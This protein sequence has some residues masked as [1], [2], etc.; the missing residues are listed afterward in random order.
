MF[1]P[2]DLS[3]FAD[4]VLDELA[5]GPLQLENTL[6][7]DTISQA[8][9][10]VL[11]LGC[12]YG[13]VT[14]PL[15]QRGIDITGLDLSAPSLDYARQQAADLP[16]RWIEADVRDFH[17]G[18]GY[19]LIF[20]RG[21]IFNFML[22][23]MDQEA[24]L[25]CV[26][27]HMGH[28]ARFLFDVCYVHPDELVDDREEEEWA[29][30]TDPQGRRLYVAGKSRFEHQRQLWIQTCTHRLE[31]AEGELVAPPWELT[32]RYLMPQ[33]VEALLHYNGFQVIARYADWDGTPVS[34]DR[35]AEVY[36]CEKR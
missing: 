36:I 25:A 32:L 10:P 33:E 19:A 20:A 23:R 21:C 17:L 1:E 16:I 7:Y 5:G 3:A 6:F 30:V 9:G 2:I 13:R 29:T 11:E 12:G 31:N 14:I 15:A 22:R 18:M 4:P 24:M 35:P 26:R 27:E 34:E 28:G 8:Q